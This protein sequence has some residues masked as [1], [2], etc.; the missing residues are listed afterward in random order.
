[1]TLRAVGTAILVTVIT[2]LVWAVA[3]SQTLQS[4]EIRA[5]VILDPGAAA[6]VLRVAPGARWEGRVQM[7][8]EGPAGV[9][10]RLRGA[11]GD[12]LRL[13]VGIELQAGDGD[14]VFDLRD[15]IA[16]SDLIRGTGVRVLTVDPPE[17]AARVEPLV[18]RE[19]PVTVVL[20]AG[21][22]E[23]PPI[24]SPAKVTVWAPE[25]WSERLPASV[26]ARIPAAAVAALRP[27]ET[28]AVP[29]VPVGFP[30][31]PPTAWGIR[32]EPAVVTA[33]VAMLART[34]ETTMDRIPIELSLPPDEVGRWRVELHPEDRALLGLR[35]RGPAASVSRV[36]SGQVR[37]RAV[38]ELTS[39]GLAAR[40]DR[41]PVELFGLPSG[42]GPVDEAPTVRLTITP[43]DP[44]P[45]AP[46]PE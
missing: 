29:G 31:L 45:D 13:R 10:E 37:V 26:T 28:V 43:I 7:E 35:V 18:Q 19:F 21:E 5:E 34:S 39:E 2:L 30:D 1:M 20:D 17:V 4:D 11:A 16:R 15:A 44:D 36:A 32:I 23:R 24:P 38:V 3:E 14:V 27:G 42:V 12:G 8:V 41:R 25:S 9:L 46:A 22:A 40:V 6:R 33:E